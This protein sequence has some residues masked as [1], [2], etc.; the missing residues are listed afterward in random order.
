MQFGFELVFTFTASPGRTRQEWESRQS[1]VLEIPGGILDRAADADGCSRQISPSLSLA[2]SVSVSVSVSLSLS[3]SLS[4]SDSLSSTTCRSC[5]R[6]ALYPKPKPFGESG[7]SAGDPAPPETPC[8]KLAGPSH[9]C[10]DDRKSD[11]LKVAS[12]RLRCGS[13]RKLGVPYFGVPIIRILLFRVL[14]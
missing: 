1:K 14:D 10:N 6:C 13:F 5:H 9:T 11:A 4:L 12:L 2:P 8:S 7:L 3:L